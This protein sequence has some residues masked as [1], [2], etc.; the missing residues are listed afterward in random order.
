M[1]TKGKEVSYNRN[2]AL[3]NSYVKRG[4]STKIDLEGITAIVDQESHSLQ[5]LIVIVQGL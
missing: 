2:V 3:F 5:G 4:F 1:S